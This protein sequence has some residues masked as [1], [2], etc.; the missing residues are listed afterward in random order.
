MLKHELQNII[1][2]ENETSSENLIQTVT[3]FLRT[4]KESSDEA[5]EGKFTTKE[6]ETKK[7]IAFIDE[8]NLW[9]NYEIF[10][11]NKIEE[12]TEQKV[13]FYNDNIGG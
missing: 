10:E 13:Y 12:G 9:Y 8:E 7:L 3:R 5:K 4:S 6:P 1:S 11:A 2:G